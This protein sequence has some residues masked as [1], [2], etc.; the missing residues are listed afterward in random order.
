[1][2]GVDKGLTIFR[3]RP[4]AVYAIEALKQVT[5]R[6]LVNANR[7]HDIYAGFGYP[8]VAD[9][10]GDFN[11]PLAGLLS[12]MRVADTPLLLIVPCDSPLVR[13]D[14]LERLHATLLAQNAD[15]CVA[16]DGERLHPVFLIVRRSLVT[17]L[18]DYLAGGERKVEGWLRR[19]RLALAD[20]SDHPEMFANVNTE[21]ELA[22]LGLES[23]FSGQTGS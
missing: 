9:A 17:S 20:F 14:L 4:L 23:R 19:H 5:D 11:G 6:I 13:G 7:H 1:M 10:D 16:H 12:A 2:G 8:V 3:G 21:E 18:A 15:I 22:R